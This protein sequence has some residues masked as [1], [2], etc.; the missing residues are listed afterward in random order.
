MPLHKCLRARI[1]SSTNGSETTSLNSSIL[2]YR[3]ENGRTYHAYM[4]GCECL[5]VTHLT[6]RLTHWSTAAHILPND[7]VGTLLTSI[8]SVLTHSLDVVGE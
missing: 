6:Q 7:E 8:H 2:K 1:K 5:N 3:V 4:E